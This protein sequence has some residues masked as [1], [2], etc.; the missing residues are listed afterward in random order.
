MKG[1]LASISG[2]AIY[3]KG[4]YDLRIIDSNIINSIS[5]R[6]G[7]IICYYCKLISIIN[8]NISENKALY[9]G[10]AIEYNYPSETDT[11]NNNNLTL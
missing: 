10:G 3:I 7:A 11:I 6:G 4:F 5:Y 1:N 2:G 8:S 9:V